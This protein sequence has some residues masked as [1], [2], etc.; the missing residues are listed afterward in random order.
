MPA[1]RAEGDPI[2]TCQ[3]VEMVGTAPSLMART[4]SDARVASIGPVMTCAPSRLGCA[5]SKM[6]F[7][8]VA[9]PFTI[10]GSQINRR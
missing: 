6:S 3:A 7:V 1:K 10:T 4:Y 2:H 5:R 8:S 9:I